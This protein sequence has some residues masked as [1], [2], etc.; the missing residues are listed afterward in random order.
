MQFQDYSW[1]HAQ[2][3]LCLCEHRLYSFAIYII[4]CVP[5]FCSINRSECVGRWN[6]NADV[7][8]S[9]GCLHAVEHISS[10]DIDI[11][12]DF[13]TITRSLTEPITIVEGV[14]LLSTLVTIPM[15]LPNSSC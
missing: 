8:C 11:T 14:T 9:A 3:N 13:D 10:T 1:K 12:V 15:S 7:H 5:C 6:S 2:I 4:I